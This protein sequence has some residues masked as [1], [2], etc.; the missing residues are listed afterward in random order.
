LSKVVEGET[1]IVRCLRVG[2]RGGSPR[3]TA[4]LKIK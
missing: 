4:P 3:E 1:Q 2:G